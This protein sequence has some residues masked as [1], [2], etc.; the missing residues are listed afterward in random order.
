MSR[1]TPGGTCGAGVASVEVNF[2]IRSFLSES[3]SENEK[4]VLLFVEFFVQKSVSPSMTHKYKKNL[5]FLAE[6]VKFPI[7][8]RETVHYNM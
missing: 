2:I 4:K 8:I 1:N 6:N 7:E 5:T 3:M